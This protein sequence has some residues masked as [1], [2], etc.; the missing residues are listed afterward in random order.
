MKKKVAI[1]DTLGAHGGSFHF[2]VFGQCMG[3]LKS[4]VKVS[5]YTNN[6]TQ[7]PNIEGLNLFIF[8]KNIF[9]SKYR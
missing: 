9:A 6:E 5:L 7:D 2:Y 8:Y 3:L 1:I 4:N